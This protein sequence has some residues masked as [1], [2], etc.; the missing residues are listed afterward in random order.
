[1]DLSWDSFIVP[2]DKPRYSSVTKYKYHPIVGKHNYRVIM[3][4]VEKVTDKE[5]YESFHNFYAWFSNN[6]V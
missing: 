4:L 2:K 3:N 1:M 6:T 5:E